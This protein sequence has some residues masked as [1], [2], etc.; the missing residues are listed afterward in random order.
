MT[1]PRCQIEYNSLHWGECPHCG[2]LNGH[3]GHLEG[4]VKTSAILISTD[5]GGVFG[6]IDEVPESLRETLVACTSGPNAA[7]I[8][9]ADQGGRAR[10]AA[11]LRALPPDPS[12]R[13]GP[14]AG[15]YT[16]SYTRFIGARPVILCAGF[17]VAGISGALVW[18]AISYLK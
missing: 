7:T 6:S 4:V 18:L 11:G 9:I 12:A 1:C 2:T 8:V 5:D 14:A 17:L 10:L 15:L 16:Q 13:I 3:P